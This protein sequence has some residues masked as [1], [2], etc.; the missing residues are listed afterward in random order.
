MMRRQTSEKNVGHLTDTVDN[1]SPVSFW[2]WIMG[3]HKKDRFIYY[4]SSTAHVNINAEL[5][6]SNL[7]RFPH[8]QTECANDAKLHVICK[9]LRWTSAK[10]DY[11]CAC[12]CRWVWD[13]CV[14]DGGYKSYS[15]VESLPWM[16]AC[17]CTKVH[18]G[19]SEHLL[20]LYIRTNWHY[21]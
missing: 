21:N 11:I 12:L 7:N 9:H 13:G 3:T 4:N 14:F 19:N 10:R 16:R 1:L 15:S 8:F 17:V 2:L 20:S 6:S 5:H 18:C